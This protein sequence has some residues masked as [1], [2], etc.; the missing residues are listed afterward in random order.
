MTLFYRFA[1]IVVN[2]WLK[3]A[4]W[5]VL[6]KENIPLDEPYLII[7]NHRENY[8]PM[9]IGCAFPRQ[10]HFLYKSEFEKNRLIGCL[11]KLCG[12]IPLKRGEADL[13]AM[14]KALAELKKGD[15]VCIF[16]EGG[17]NKGEELKEFKEGGAFLAY[18]AK[19]KI[20]PVAIINSCDFVRFW[21]KNVRVI[22]GKPLTVNIE[23]N[24]RESM[25]K[26]NKLTREIVGRMLQEAKKSPQ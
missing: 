21:K 18:K 10:V 22:I 2:L 4:G 9:L 15:A 5:R 7:A 8:D 19:V 11:F 3:I 1:F 25:D 6:G 16:P 17:R 23:D 24:L 12:A 14:K 26:Y 13:V 20:I